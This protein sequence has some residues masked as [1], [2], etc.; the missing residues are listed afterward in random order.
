MF[1]FQDYRIFV[2]DSWKHYEKMMFPGINDRYSL[3]RTTRKQGHVDTY[4]QKSCI[5]AYFLVLHLLVN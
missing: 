2:I 4:V 5:S 1:V 3:P